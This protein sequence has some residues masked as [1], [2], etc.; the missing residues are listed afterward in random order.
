MDQYEYERQFVQLQ[1]FIEFYK[2]NA[3]KGNKKSIAEEEAK[4]IT[5]FD[6]ILAEVKKIHDQIPFNYDWGPSLE[7]EICEVMSKIFLH[8]HKKGIRKSSPNNWL[9]NMS[10]RCGDILIAIING[11]GHLYGIY[12]DEYEMEK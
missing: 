1:L 8:N 7:N 9:N 2:K 6:Y 4:M 12:W 3:Y 11:H 10:I 5:C